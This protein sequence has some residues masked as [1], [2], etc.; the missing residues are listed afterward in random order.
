MID[1]ILMTSEN[2]MIREYCNA[3]IEKLEEY[4]A[5]SMGRMNESPVGRFMK[6]ILFKMIRK[7]STEGRDNP[8]END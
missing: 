3:N 4:V 5:K 7:D 6:D 2:T 1:L 8:E